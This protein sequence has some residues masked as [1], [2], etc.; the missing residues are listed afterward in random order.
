ML[1]GAIH[2]LRKQT[3]IQL[4]LADV[5]A[6]K[7][8]SNTFD[9][10]NCA[11]S[12]HCFPEVQASFQEI[13]RVLEPNGTFAGNVLLHPRGS[14]PL[15]R[16]AKWINNW[17]IR[18]DILYTPYNKEEVQTLLRQNGFEIIKENVSGN[19]YDFLAKKVG[20]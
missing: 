18:K 14:G 8:A 12:I 10:V 16:V 11:N 4:E 2:R 9:T 1:E 5:T 7:Y 13:H 20:V 19:C 17:G 6:L 15:D 3:E